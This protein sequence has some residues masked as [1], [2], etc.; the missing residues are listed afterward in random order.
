MNTNVYNII[1]ADDD[2]DALEKRYERRFNDNHLFII[3]RAH[4]GEELE[5]VLSEKINYVDAVIV[6]A[7]FNESEVSVDDERDTSGLTF[8]RVHL[9]K[10]YPSIPFFLFTQ[11][12]DELI[13]EKFRNTPKFLNEFPRH[14]RWFMKNDD[15][16][17]QEMFES[18]VNEV[19]YRNSDQFR[20]RNKYKKEFAAAKLI[21]DAE[22]NLEKGL[23]YLYEDDS[24]GNVQDFFNP[25]R[26]I[27]ER[28]FAN[29]MDLKILPPKTSLNNASRYFS[30]TLNDN[31]IRLK[32]EV[33]PRTLAES[34]YYFLK[35]TQD[36]SHDENDMGLGV[37]KYVR[38]NHNI[39]LY[40]TILYIVM[41]LLIWYDKVSE[42]YKNN[43][44]PLWEEYFEY[45]GKVCYNPQWNFFY[46]GQYE[47]AKSPNL[48][49]G[50]KVRIYDSSKN[51]NKHRSS[52]YPK[53]VKEKDYIILK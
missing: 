41:D 15:D 1:W 2:I 47:L 29:C 18:I 8:A 39:N 10:K 13:K 53:F 24:W 37:D 14:K 27:V 52:Q 4:N 17:L 23:L 12:A 5:R 43:Q 45:E 48:K 20:I 9:L 44:L 35:I 28:I 26:K 51:D 34:L 30:N 31:H 21:E 16:E 6:D 19:N 46:S 7:N 32:E 36:G 49:D 33:M 38:E 22:R 3:G 42:K 25:A 40:R 50:A 11:R